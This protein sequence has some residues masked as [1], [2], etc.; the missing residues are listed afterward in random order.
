MFL[1]HTESSIGIGVKEGLIL[2]FNEVGYLATTSLPISMESKDVVHDMVRYF[3]RLVNIQRCRFIIDASG[4]FLQHQQ[5]LCAIVHQSNF[6]ND[7]HV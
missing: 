6:K 5:I 7:I 2:K 1:Y 3:K 4:I